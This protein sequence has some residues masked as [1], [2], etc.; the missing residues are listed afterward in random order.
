MTDTVCMSDSETLPTLKG[1]NLV[2]FRCLNCLA[3]LMLSRIHLYTNLFEF[4]EQ[5]PLRMGFEVRHFEI[6]H[7]ANCDP[8][9]A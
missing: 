6:Q 7:V 3:V 1:D 8:K 4:T 9:L 2:V 5:W